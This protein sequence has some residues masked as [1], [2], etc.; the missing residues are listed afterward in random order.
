MTY[1]VRMNTS[2]RAIIV[3][4]IAGMVLLGGMAAPVSAAPT[5][6]TDRDGEAGT[7]IAIPGH[8][9][10][11][12]GDGTAPVFGEIVFESELP[13]NPPPSQAM[14]ANQAQFPRSLQVTLPNGRRIV[15]EVGAKH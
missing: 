15:R 13:A 12:G 4:V 3:L 6:T 2:K 14:I 1:L 10:D 5:D 7:V 11:C 9:T 8:P